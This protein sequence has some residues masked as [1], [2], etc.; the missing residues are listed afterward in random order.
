MTN[1]RQMSFTILA[2]SVLGPQE[3]EINDRIAYILIRDGKSRQ[4]LNE[5]LNLDDDLPYYHQ[6]RPVFSILQATADF[7][8][9]SFEWLATGNG[10]PESK[11]IYLSQS[12]TISGSAI[13][14]GNQAGSIHVH[15]YQEN[16]GGGQP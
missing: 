16:K 13:V 4:S 14:S 7:L 3:S 5:Y 11:T 2:F 1:P 12:P 10:S 15:N 8:G 9:V 6:K